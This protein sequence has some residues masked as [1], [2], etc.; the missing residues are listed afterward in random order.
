MTAVS[1]G[2]RTPPVRADHS[3]LLRSLRAEDPKQCLEA[4]FHRAHSVW[5]ASPGTAV[6]KGT[7]SVQQTSSGFRLTNMLTK[8]TV[9]VDRRAREPLEIIAASLGPMPPLDFRVGDLVHKCIGDFVDPF[10]N[11][12]EMSHTLASFAVMHCELSLFSYKDWTVSVPNSQAKGLADSFKIVEKKSGVYEIPAVE[13]PLDIDDDKLYVYVRLVDV[14]GLF[15]ELEEKKAVSIKEEIERMLTTYFGSSS[16]MA[17]A[18]S[19]S[20]LYESVELYLSK[21]LLKALR[22]LKMSL[23]LFHDKPVLLSKMSTCVRILD[24]AS[25]I[26][27]VVAKTTVANNDIANLAKQVKDQLNLIPQ[28]FGTLKPLEV[29]ISNEFLQQIKSLGI[30]GINQQLLPEPDSAKESSIMRAIEEIDQQNVRERRPYLTV[31]GGK[32]TASLPLMWKFKIAEPPT[33]LSHN[34]HC[35]YSISPKGCQV[36]AIHYAEDVV[37]SPAFF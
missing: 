4:I 18:L 3:R 25:L 5:A 26:S 27:K 36:F 16:L 12:S 9:D 2:G 13:D 14:E 22:L 29:I 11:R 6:I 34:A 19:M 21:D 7:V 23:G 33:W 15:K 28:C 30:A 1:P 8:K 17:E 31:Q 20:R 24:P 32:T 37:E 35:Y 10:R